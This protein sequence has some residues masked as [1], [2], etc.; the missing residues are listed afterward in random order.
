VLLSVGV[1]WSNYRRCSVLL[2]GV[3]VGQII[4]GVVCCSVG[5]WSDYRRCSVLLSGL[6]VGQI[7]GGVV[8]CSVGCGY[9]RL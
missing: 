1:G 4:G 5:G 8:C 6:S 3:C 2:S 7:I 9:V